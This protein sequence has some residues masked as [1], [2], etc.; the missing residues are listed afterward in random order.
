[1]N[2]KQIEEKS[3]ELV[4]AL[5]LYIIGLGSPVLVKS[6]LNCLFVDILRMLDDQKKDNPSLDWKKGNFE[7]LLKEL[8]Q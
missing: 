8:T 5:R 4:R 2:Q 7:Q 6:A 3:E 1:M